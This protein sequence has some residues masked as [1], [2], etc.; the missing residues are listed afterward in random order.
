[1]RDKKD[2]IFNSEILHQ[3]AYLTNEQFG[4]MIR[5][6]MIEDDQQTEKRYENLNGIFFTSYQKKEE[7]W[8]EEFNNILDNPTLLSAYSVIYG[9]AAEKRKGY[10]DLKDKLDSKKP[11]KTEK[12]DKTKSGKKE[13]QAKLYKESFLF[14]DNSVIVSCLESNKG[15]IP[16]KEDITKLQKQYDDETIIEMLERGNKYKWVCDF[17]TIIDEIEFE[18]MEKPEDIKTEQEK[19]PI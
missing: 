17:G 3:T 15:N 12:P 8:K 6:A 10:N 16:N 5:I 19:Y 7:E 1:M 11:D 2:S 13:P 4:L 14:D 18:R 9:C